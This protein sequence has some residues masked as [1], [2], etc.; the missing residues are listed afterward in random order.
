MPGIHRRSN[1]S[2]F[3][4]CVF[5]NLITNK[6]SKITIMK[7]TLRLL[8]LL[9][10]SVLVYGLAACGSDDEVSPQLSVPAGVDNYF[11]KS[12][13]FESAAAEKS[14][15]F[16]SNLAWTLSVSETRNGID[17]L[18]VSPSSGEAGTHTVTVKAAE[19]K[20]YDDRNAV[21][22]ITSGDS[23]RKVFVNQKQLDALTLTSNRFEVPVE[24]GT[25]E[26][27]VKSNIE[28]EVI[29]PNEC[30]T[31]IHQVN[32]QTRGLSTSSLSF[33][34]DR[35]EEYDKREGNIIIKGKDKAETV[36]VYQAGEGILTLTKNEYNLSSSAQELAIEI[37]SNF[38]YSVEL[39][40]VDWLKEVTAQTRGISTHSLRL[41]VAGNDSY[42]DRS[43]KIRVYD[44]NSSISEEVII[45]QSQKNALI[46]ENK[47][48]TLDENGGNFTV[49]TNSNINY[50]VKIDCNWI[51]ET[52]AT[53]RGLVASSHSFSVSAI[54]DN[55]DRQ[56]TI[57]FYDT[58]TGIKEVVI[59]KQ[60]KSIYFDEN[61][62]TMIEESE[63]KLN[64]TNKSNLGI[65]WR[66][67]T[68][69][70][71]SVDD[72]GNVKALSKGKTTITATS[73]DGLHI[74]K[75]EVLVKNIADCISIQRT[76]WSSVV[77]PWGSSY[78]VTFTIKNSSPETI[79]IV[80]LGGVTEGVAQDLAGGNSVAITLSSRSESAVQAQQKLIYTYKGK[81]YSID[82]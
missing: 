69:S 63:R 62:I 1:L 53:T 59:V 77:S 37:S 74:C 52:T 54:T 28:Y 2:T 64:L 30:K 8:G 11:V 23:I 31:W 71:A 7:K 14:F 32:K 58:T 78:S 72:N 66:S 80:S 68:P 20:T 40:D 47:E 25:V 36:T 17:W 46:I 55:S 6:R 15:T 26:I 13:D 82:G 44:R 21:I 10:L 56:G 29:I 48:Y 61:T 27:E 33:S 12:M 38:D 70:V 35:C 65:I 42:D 67:S 41:S 22:T 73:E 16:N 79:H 51:K 19:N 75:C 34:I 24:G 43:A 76:G 50:G 3:S 45:N 5:S 9:L 4:F 60:N 49:E 57:T 18:S 81:Q 39:P